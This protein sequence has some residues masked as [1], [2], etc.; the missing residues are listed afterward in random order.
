MTWSISK[1]F[2][3]W[4][5]VLSSECMGARLDGGFQTCYFGPTKNQANI[6][7][8][9]SCL[10]KSVATGSNG[11][12]SSA[13]RQTKLSLPI[14]TWSRVCIIVHRPL[15]IDSEWGICIVINQRRRRLFLYCGRRGVE[16]GKTDGCRLRSRRKWSKGLRF[17]VGWYGQD[18]YWIAL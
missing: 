14:T 9:L 8:S 1:D 15:Y 18:G 17:R 13:I 10:D 2:R 6:D 12:P 4:C 11:D 7:G 3:V 5:Y 16:V